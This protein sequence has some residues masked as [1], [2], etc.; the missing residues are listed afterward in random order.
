MLRDVV[1]FKKKFYPRGWAN[2]DDAKPGSLKLL[3]PKHARGALFGDYESMQDMIFGR[4][5]SFQEI[6]DGLDALEA[7]INN[8]GKEVRR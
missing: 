7:E 3:P 5:P 1:A 6:L 8:L 4:N 2:Y